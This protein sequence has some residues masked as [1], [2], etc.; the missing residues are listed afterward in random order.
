[1][2]NL[3]FYVAVLGL[4]MFQM[5]MGLI[6]ISLICGGVYH[7]YLKKMDGIKYLATVF[8]V[9]AVSAIINPLFSHKGAT[10]LFYLF[11]GNPVTLESIVYG[12]A[13]AAIIC[14]MLLWFSSFNVIMTEDKLLAGI[15]TVM[16]HA[17][18]L[19]T[20]VFRFVPKFVRQGRAVIDANRALGNSMTGIRNKIKM[21]TDMFSITTTWALENSVDTADSMRARGYG[22]G[23]RTSY[24]N[25]KFQ[26]RDVVMILWI[27]ILFVLVCIEIGA[28]E[29]VTYYYPVIRIKG[30]LLVY[31][32][33]TVLCM[34]PMIINVGEA[35]RWHRFRSKI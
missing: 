25:Y 26:T 4:T 15:G 31:I 9:F 21:Q 13:T 10:L 30:N 33:Y 11:T 19:L 22:T 12:M 35:V 18:M 14:A 5:Q 27:L 28:G 20:M 7:F 8:F 34:M 1:M 29:A 24:N 17:A 32:T 3:I 2:V 16:P 23:K 6:M